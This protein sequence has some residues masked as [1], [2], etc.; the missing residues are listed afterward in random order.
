[1][2]LSQVFYISVY[3]LACLSGG[4]L[5]W[6]EGDL[7][8]TGLT[9]P[10]GIAAYFLNEKWR[11]IRLSGVWVNSLALVAFV[12]PAMEFFSPNIEGRLLAGAH[13]LVLLQ[14]IVFLQD[15][16]PQQY[17][18]IFAL[19]ILQ[20]AVSAVLTH[21]GLFGILLLVYLLM[22]MWSLSVF[23]LFLG[24]EKFQE[25]TDPES[26]REPAR[27]VPLAYALASAGGG[28]I[29]V[30]DLGRGMPSLVANA[31]QRP[32]GGTWINR[33]FA[34]GVIAMSFAALFIG[35][36]FFLAIPRYWI[37][38]ITF[39][40]QSSEGGGGIQ[41]LS[42]FSEKVT[43]GDFGQILESPAVVMKV[44]FQNETTSEAVDIAT[45]AAAFGMEEPLFTGTVLVKYDGKG[46][47]SHPKGITEDHV[48]SLDYRGADRSRAPPYLDRLRQ[49]YQLEPIGSN[50]LFAMRPLD[51]KIQ[52][53]IADTAGGISKQRETSVLTRENSDS[54]KGI[55]YAILTPLHPNE[56]AGRETPSEEYLRQTRKLPP[57]GLERLQ[58]LTVEALAPL[59]SSDRRTPIL[60]MERARRLESHLR[61]SGDY[62]YSLDDRIINP[63]I[64][65][66][67]DFLFNRKSGHCEYFA[68]ALTLML[69]SANIPARL[70]TG[71]K[72]GVSNRNKEFEVQQRHAHAW[73]EAYI[74]DQKRWVMF[75]ATPAAARQAVVE[76]AVGPFA[77]WTSFRQGFTDFWHY[78]I[79]SM[80]LERQEELLFGPLKNMVANGASTTG[81]MK[82]NNAVLIIQAI[83]AF[84]LSPAQW[85]S[86]RG[87]V[88][89]LAI[90]LGST[91]GVAAVR[92]L[93]KLWRR[94]MGGRRRGN[95]SR[96]GRVDFY[97][98]FIAIMKA[99]GFSRNDAQ[100]QREFADEVRN[101]IATRLQPHGL[102]LLPAELSDA[103]YRVRFGRNTLSV[104]EHHRLVEQLDRL[105]TCLAAQNVPA[106]E[107]V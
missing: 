3:S 41:P 4:M 92:E 26:A 70:V 8:P 20:V 100:T 49:S 22:A 85:V 2:E 19:S 66:V 57:G 87:A 32:D 102:A 48:Q 18:W 86:W 31:T 39:R 106:G 95:A 46:R 13:L 59:Q 76:Q 81:L 56:D 9:L 82:M 24:A 67:E 40:S 44:A 99:H 38:G 64:D 96:P 94:L 78:Y 68:S 62:Q 29:P 45:H 34:G 30:M 69:R 36:G 107:S 89:A 90:A 15:K 77:W 83:F 23:S 28:G 91:L 16:Q 98:A 80:S 74:K 75:D 1:M 97:E 43:L 65:P 25:E 21:S 6:A 55:K 103:F 73:V 51:D 33:R 104:A 105:K 84:L 12:Y 42:G 17:W 61:D 5:A 79:F 27:P 11:V 37:G 60:D 63:E 88:V 58:Q 72:G 93:R 47:W 52:A 10:I 7:L 35:F 53:K 54:N 50:V 71:F 14:W 101:A